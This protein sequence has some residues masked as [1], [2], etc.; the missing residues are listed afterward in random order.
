MGGDEEEEEAVVARSL[1]REW[2]LLEIGALKHQISFLSLFLIVRA[3]ASI[4]FIS[5]LRTC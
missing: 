3:Q 4:E 1:A 2:F 5:L